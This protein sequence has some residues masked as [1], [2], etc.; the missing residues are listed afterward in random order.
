MDKTTSSTTTSSK[1]SYLVENPLAGLNLEGA[2]TTNIV[3]KNKKFTE[4]KEGDPSMTKKKDAAG[5]R[6]VA[7]M[8][9]PLHHD[10]KN[11]NTGK[12]RKKKKRGCL[13]CICQPIIR[14]LVCFL[15]YLPFFFP[16]VVLA[17]VAYCSLSIYESFNA[18][19]LIIDTSVEVCASSRYFENFMTNQMIFILTMVIILFNVLVVCC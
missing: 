13:S 3:P 14:G 7:N 11:K 2:T 4:L 6:D 18:G 16:V 1:S 10:K 9:Q 17:L 8:K 15:Y 5:V 12:K 19:N